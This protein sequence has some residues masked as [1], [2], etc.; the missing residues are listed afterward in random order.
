[1]ILF[2]N[3]R[4][5]KQKEKEDNLSRKN[6]FQIGRKERKYDILIKKK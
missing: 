6:I 1:M 2:R 5:L 4:H 3:K